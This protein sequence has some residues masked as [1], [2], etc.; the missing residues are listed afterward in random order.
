MRSVASPTISFGLISVPTKAYLGASSESFSFKMITPEGNLVK[1]KIFDAVTD[2]E[3]PRGDCLKGYEYAKDQYLTFT[4]ADIDALAGDNQNSIEL[5]EF[6]DDSAFNPIQVEKC[7][8]LAPD[9]GAEKSYRLL[10]TT[11][12]NLGKV[13]VG[14][15]YTRGKDHLVILKATGGHITLFQ[16][17]YANEVRAFEYQFSDKTAPTDQELALAKRLINQLSTKQFDVKKYSDEFAERI[18]AAIDAKING[19]EETVAPATTAK[20][21]II[22]LMEL[23]KASIEAQETGGIVRLVDGK[24]DTHV[25]D[26]LGGGVLPPPYEEPTPPSKPGL[27]KTK[28]KKK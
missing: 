4:E 18:R 12:E 5:K 13:A 7:Y 23:L 24:V 25:G 20:P 10:T 16:M 14:K 17:Y 21:N 19:G 1:Q 8:Y 28:G 9:K 22:D 2:K 26:D 11:L 15:W 6:V 3:V 27:K